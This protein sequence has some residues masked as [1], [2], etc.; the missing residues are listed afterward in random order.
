MLMLALVAAPSLGDDPA[1]GEALPDTEELLARERIRSA[2]ESIWEAYYQPTDDGDV[3]VDMAIRAAR[4]FAELGSEAVPYLINE[5]EQNKRASYD[6]CAYALGL[7]GTAEAR[8]ALH[9]AI[10]RA[11]EMTGDAAR[12]HKAWA[13]WGLGLAG[14]PQAIRL[15][16]QGR[17]DASVYPMHGGMTMMES[18][19]VQTAPQ[20]VPVLLELLASVA[21][22]QERWQARRTALRALRRVGD[23]TAVP[24]LIKLFEHPDRNVRNEVAN[25]L[26]SMPTPAAVDLLVSA[27]ADPDFLV[28]RVAAMALEQVGTRRHREAI[29]GRLRVEEDSVT[30]GRLYRV[31]AEAGGD[32]AFETLMEF[33]DH[34]DRRDRRSFVEAV[35]LL[36]DARRIP[37]LAA[38][39][40]DE[41]NGVALEAAIS[42]GNL[43][44]EDAVAAL[45]DAMAGARPPVARIVSE[46]LVRL[47]AVDSAAAIAGRIVQELK[48]DSAIDHSAAIV[49]EKMA[50]ALVALSHVQAANDL[51][52][53]LAGRKDATGTAPLE[54]T[55]VALETIRKCGRRSSRWIETAAS[56]DSSLRQLAYVHLGRIGSAEALRSLTTRFDDADPTDRLAI[57][58]ALGD[59]EESRALPLLERVL[60]GP[61]FD[62]APQAPLRSMAA[63]SARRIGGRAMWDLLESA[64]IRREGRDAAVLIYAALVDNE[65]GVELLERVRRQRMR[66]I[67]WHKGKELERLDWLAVRLKSGRSVWQVDVAPAK[68]NL[69]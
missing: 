3:R 2:V 35:S 52:A 5:L 20:S 30:R 46:Q 59:V 40:H 19:A 16:A 43:G 21:D 26:R 11:E 31:V 60:L 1:G 38:S 64:A 69:R 66:F 58:R 56:D 10:S 17:H 23:T 4:D 22:D 61:E 44:S 55:L 14:D 28:R 37:F 33:R 8:E 45:G 13:A 50:D 48:S 25:T 32:R 34:E 9:T 68:L 54:R 12:S 41:D 47:R 51:R 36:D 63:W 7:A 53:A 49:L 24:T 18:I 67:G 62:P 39:L 27:I 65:R 57:L 42:L 15:L 29:L 6:L